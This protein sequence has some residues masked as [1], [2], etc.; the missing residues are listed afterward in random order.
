MTLEEKKD[1]AGG[2]LEA[3]DTI[4]VEKSGGWDPKRHWD[5]DEGDE[6]VRYRRRW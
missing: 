4:G 2:K 6:H 1:D 3:G 5:L